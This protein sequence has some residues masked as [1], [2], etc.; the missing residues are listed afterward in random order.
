MSLPKADVLD[1]SPEELERLRRKM[2]GFGASGVLLAGL[3]PLAVASAI[4]CVRWESWPMRLE[5]IAAIKARWAA[6]GRESFSEALV[7]RVGPKETQPHEEFRDLAVI[8][9]VMAFVP[10]GVR[11]FGW[12]WEETE[13]E[14]A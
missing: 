12:H 5:R 8:L 9:A 6:E 14:H 11:A 7:V 3:L 1:D 2:D 10:G 4:D 13:D